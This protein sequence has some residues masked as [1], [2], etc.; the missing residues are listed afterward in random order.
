VLP[1]E[2]FQAMSLLPHVRAINNGYGMS[3][4]GAITTTSDLTAGLSEIRRIPACPLASVG[5]LYPHTRLK[6][7]DLE[8]KQTLGPLEKGELVVQSLVM[9]TGYWKQF[10]ETQATFSRGWL[11]TGDFGYYDHDGFVY[12]LDRVKETFKYFNNHVRDNLWIIINMFF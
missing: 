2:F 3:E 10:D 7:I 5:R 1:L 9:C 12:V 8:T 4:C 11:Y 6:V